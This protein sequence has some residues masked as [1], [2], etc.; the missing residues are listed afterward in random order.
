MPPVVAL[1]SAPCPP[2]ARPSGKSLSASASRRSTKS[3]Y[4]HVTR[5]HTRKHHGKQR[6]NGRDQAVVTEGRGRNAELPPSPQRRNSD[7]C[8]ILTLY[9]YDD[10]DLAPAIHEGCCTSV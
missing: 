5:G 4:C 1:S 7:A 8:L 2:P 9:L 3:W 10:L 6:G